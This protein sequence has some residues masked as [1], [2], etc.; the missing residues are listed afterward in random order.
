MT[1]KVAKTREG[2]SARNGQP[3]N[4]PYVYRQQ[5][6]RNTY[7][8]RIAQRNV[9]ESGL[10]AD[11]AADPDAAVRAKRLAARAELADEAAAATSP[12]SWLR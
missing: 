10:S 4:V 8:A 12:A 1:I 11:V 9:E 3:E 7:A 5:Q 2:I 6:R